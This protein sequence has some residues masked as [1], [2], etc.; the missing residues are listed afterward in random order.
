MSVAAQKPNQTV[1]DRSWD[2]EPEIIGAVDPELQKLGIAVF[3]PRAFNEIRRV[4]KLRE[5]DPDYFA[6]DNISHL[7]QQKIAEVLRNYSDGAMTLNEL[8][9]MGFD[10]YARIAFHL[11][12]LGMAVTPEL[13]EIMQ[14]VAEK[15]NKK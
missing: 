9:A 15:V 12:R 10:N 2:S 5:I 8:G 6:D 11:T 4:Q 1:Q 14:R 13:T 3:D 7:S